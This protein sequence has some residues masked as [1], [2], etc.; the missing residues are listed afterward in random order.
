MLEILWG[1]ATPQLGA[2]HTPAGGLQHPRRSSKRCSPIPRYSQNHSVVLLITGNGW[3]VISDKVG[4][5]FANPTLPVS[6]LFS[7]G[8]P[9]VD[10]K[11]WSIWWYLESLDFDDWWIRFCC[12][13]SKNGCISGS[14]HARAILRPVLGLRFLRFWTS[15]FWIWGFK[16]EKAA[17]KLFGQ[18]FCLIIFNKI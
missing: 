6:R 8:K 5:Y 15:K 7:A 18:S 14:S 11:W 12:L 9:R 16:I 10:I 4:R 17:R 2:C 1:L 3:T 13:K